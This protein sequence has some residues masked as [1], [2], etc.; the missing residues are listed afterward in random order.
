MKTDVSLQTKQVLSQ[1]QV[2]SLN[3]L[4]MSAPELQEYLQ[5]EEIENPIVEYTM[6]SQGDSTPAVFREYDRFYARGNGDNE[7]EGRDF[8]QPQ[9]ERSSIKELVESQLSWKQMDKER[10]RIVDFCVQSLDQNGYLSLSAAEI[11][12]ALGVRENLACEMLGKLRELEPAGI[13]ASGL[14]DCL[15][16][17]V[18]GFEQQELLEQIIGNH[19]GDVAEGRISSI[20]RDLKLSSME[21]RK[22]IHVIRGLNP[23]PLNGY[24]EEQAQY[25]V[26]DILLSFS[27]GQWTVSLNDKWT[28]SFGINEFYVHMMETAQDEEL[29]TYFE[30]KLR[31]ARFIMNAVEQRRRT[32]ERITE[33]ILK[34]QAG[35]FTGKEPLRPMTLE[36][37]AMELGI[38]KSTV[39]RAIR[40]KY[41]LTPAGCLLIRN[42]FTA[43]VGDGAED[44]SRNTVKDRLKCL[45]DRENKEKP[46]SDE[47]LAGLLEQEGMAVSRRTVAKYRTELGI[48]SAFQRRN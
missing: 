12:K 42:L 31:R 37:I 38:H 3:I 15:R 22:L 44:V 20:S 40:D 10:K 27:D 8:Y 23:R 36:E 39:S 35:Y 43:G 17:Q 41:I 29:K 45:I 33:A 18:Q 9:T 46:Y 28:G 6:G 2:E 47:H 32:L 19:L 11:G 1:T 30:E 4:A 25:L 5:K 14:E 34:C 48:G 21:V 26:P 24:G 13:F 7:N 16:L